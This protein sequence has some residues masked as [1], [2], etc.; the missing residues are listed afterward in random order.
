MGE[1]RLTEVL[2]SVCPNSK[3]N[4]CGK[5]LADMEELLEEWWSNEQRAVYSPLLFMDGVLISSFYYLC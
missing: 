3:D 4:M 1:A 5:V 2:E